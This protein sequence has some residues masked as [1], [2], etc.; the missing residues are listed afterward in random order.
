MSIRLKLR[1]K[2][3]NCLENCKFVRHQLKQ[4][5]V[6]PRYNERLHD[7]DVG[8]TNDILRPINSKKYGREPRYKETSLWGTY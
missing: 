1:G 3:V 4:T 6:E 5:T 2:T 7:E 8:I